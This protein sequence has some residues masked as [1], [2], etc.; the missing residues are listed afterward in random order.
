MTLRKKIRPSGPHPVATETWWYRE[1][2]G[3]ITLVHEDRDSLGAFL[4]TNQWRISPRGVRK[5][6]GS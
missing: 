6:E 1:P 4:R 3:D 2:N 5:V